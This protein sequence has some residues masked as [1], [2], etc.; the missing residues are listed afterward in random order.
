[1]VTDSRQ[2]REP[3]ALRCAAHLRNELLY[4]GHGLIVSVPVSSSHC[5]EFLPSGGA[6]WREQLS[7]HLPS[8]RR[9]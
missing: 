2:I 8:P 7:T 4:P 3:D 9:S 1:V 6:G 5:Q